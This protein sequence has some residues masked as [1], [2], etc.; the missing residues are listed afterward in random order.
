MGRSQSLPA[1]LTGDRQP[2]RRQQ[3]QHSGRLLLGALGQ[4][5]LV[6]RR[7]PKAVP[8]NGT[9]TNG[10]SFVAVVEFSPKGVKARAISAGGESGN[11]SSP[12][13]NDQAQRYAKGDLR[14]VYFYPAQLQGHIER[15]Y[16]P[17]E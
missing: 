3:A 2:V 12:H 17:G 5:R 10:N 9:A 8:R 7:R 15:T 1:H 14:E 4:P 13:F 6:R 11:P 16:R